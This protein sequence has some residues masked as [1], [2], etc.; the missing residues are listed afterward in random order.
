MDMLSNITYALRQLRGIEG[1]DAAVDRARRAIDALERI[2]YKLTAMSESGP[3]LLSD[4]EAAGYPS[5]EQQFM[6]AS[7][8]LIDEKRQCNLCGLPLNNEPD[9]SNHAQCEWEANHG[10][11][12]RPARDEDD[13]PTREELAEHAALC[14]ASEASPEDETNVPF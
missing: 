13:G 12:H 4:K 14:A 9:G 6:D 2:K 10:D 7:L 5:P 8:R 11:D 1:S 3:R